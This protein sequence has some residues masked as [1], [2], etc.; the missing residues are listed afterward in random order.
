MIRQTET[1]SAGEF[2]AHC[3]QLMDEVKNTGR[4]LIVTKRGKP[5]AKLVPVDAQQR[6]PIGALKG[7]VTIVG[8]IVAPLDEVWHAAQ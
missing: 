3:L 5:V 4:S 6:D 8:D 2:K 7:T 1:I